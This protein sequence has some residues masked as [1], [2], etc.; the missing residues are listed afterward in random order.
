MKFTL[1]TEMTLTSQ[2]TPG[3]TIQVVVAFGNKTLG[4]WSPVEGL[5]NISSIPEFLVRPIAESCVAY[6]V[7]GKARRELPPKEPGP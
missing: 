5:Q 7:E 4:Y 2:E 3:G 1:T 6:Y